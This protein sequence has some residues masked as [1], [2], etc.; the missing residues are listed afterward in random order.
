[1]T[2]IKTLVTETAK[3]LGYDAIVTYDDYTVHEVLIQNI[4]ELNDICKSLENCDDTFEVEYKKKYELEDGSFVYS[5]KEYI[6]IDNPTVKKSFKNEFLTIEQLINKLKT[7]PNNIKV[8]VDGYEGGLDAILD[9]T[10]I[11]IEYDATK[12][13]YYGPFEES[14]SSNTQTVKLISTRGTR[15]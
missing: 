6:S 10:M 2:K 4:D 12:Q 7:Y 13:W 15:V 9:I 11:N 14:E 3:F 1:M 5:K 8:L